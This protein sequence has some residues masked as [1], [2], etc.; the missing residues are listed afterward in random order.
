M[1]RG[2]GIQDANL[3][4]IFDVLDVTGDGVITAADFDALAG[5]VATRLVPGAAED[6][7]QDIVAA[8]RDWWAQIEQDADSDGDGRVTR[9]EF[10]Q[11]IE[12]GLDR[13]PD[14]LEQSFA[15]VAETLYKALDRDGDGQVDRNEYIALYASGGVGADIAGPAFDRIDQNGDGVIDYAEF[16][17]AV[18]EMFSTAD[19]DA[20]GAALLG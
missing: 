12:Q 6:S 17:A 2:S 11:A 3:G 8:Y 1:T 14:Y 19:P 16:R 20:P 15:P 10:V 7:R 5:Q 9:E 4:K 13:N 18:Q